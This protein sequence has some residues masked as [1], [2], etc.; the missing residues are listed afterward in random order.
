[1]AFDP[2]LYMVRRRLFVSLAT[3]EYQWFV[4]PLFPGLEEIQKRISSFFFFWIFPNWICV[5]WRHRPFCGLL[6]FPSDVSYGS[7]LS[8]PFIHS[9]ANFQQIFNRFRIF[10]PPITERDFSFI[11]FLRI[12][13]WSVPL[14]PLDYSQIDEQNL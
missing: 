9:A 8:L 11:L 3:F 2:V 6:P 13:C 10:E 14:L 12:T 1:M 4:F 5:Q 7:V